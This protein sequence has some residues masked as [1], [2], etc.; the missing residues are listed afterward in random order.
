MTDGLS[1]LLCERN[2]S[3]VGPF[4]ICWIS[5]TK[6]SSKIVAED[7]PKA[8]R[9]QQNVPINSGVF[10]PPLGSWRRSM[11]ILTPQRERRIYPQPEARPNA[12]PDK[13]GVPV[14]VVVSRC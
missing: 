6:F 7:G 4:L 2:A 1:A 3:Y 14:S 10:N 5:S 9:A 11:R 12:L 8:A 13:S